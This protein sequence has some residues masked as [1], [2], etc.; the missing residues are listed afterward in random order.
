MCRWLGVSRAAYYKWLS[1]KP[2]AEEQENQRISQWIQEYDEKYYHTLGYRR[3][4]N[5]INRKQDKNYSKKRIRRLMG[6]LGIQSTIRRARHSCTKSTPE[7]AENLLKRDF[8]AGAPNQKL[9]T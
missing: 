7:T 9:S 4:C 8:Y 3:M 5:Y 1:R 2:A 6:L